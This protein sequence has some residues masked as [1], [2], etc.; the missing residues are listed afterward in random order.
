MS[1]P[2]LGID[3][4]TSNSVVSVLEA[5]RPT[6]I[7]NQ[8][9]ELTTASCVAFLPNGSVLVG[10]PARAGIGQR[11]ERTVR[12][13][14]RLV[15]R[16]S[17]SN[18]VT[19][20][21]QEMAFSLLANPQGDVRVQIDDRA[22]RLEEIAA[23]ILR[24]LASSAK[25]YLGSEDV[26]TAVITVPA[27]FNDNQRQAT[28]NAAM[29]AGLEPL[30]ILNEPTAA[31]LAYGYGDQEAKRVAVFDFGGGTFDL[32]ILEMGA[33]V[34]E[35]L[36]TGGDTYLGGD[37][38]DRMIVDDLAEKILKKTG[39][40]P[41][42]D[43]AARAVLWDLAEK[44]KRELSEHETVEIDLEVIA[45]IPM[46]YGLTRHRFNE[47]VTPL[48]ERSLEI[49]GEVLKEAETGTH[50]IDGVV[51]VGGTTRVPA[52]REA[53]RRYFRREPDTGID[54]DLVVSV[55]A[56]IYGASLSDQSRAQQ[57][58]L[59]VTPLTLRLGTVQKFT[60]AIIEKNA[61]IPTERT[62]TF[63]TSRDQQEYVAIRVFQGE[64]EFQSENTLLGEFA[65]GPLQQAPRGQVEIDVT[66]EIDPNGLVRV[67]ATDCQTGR[68]ASANVRLSVK[69]DEKSVSQ[70][71]SALP[72]ASS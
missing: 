18:E 32:S 49:C 59:D 2:V 51:L 34:L 35:V 10:N 62:R 65:F 12:S 16:S 54:P 46:V 4:G 53:V 69:M 63:V 55:G 9:G 58:L 38:M 25:S 36:A 24:D 42:E 41:R 19:K 26:K 47:L 44:S 50:L 37:D 8:D 22:Y 1:P 29:I 68:A 31:A 64:S 43:P 27:Y 57:I 23:M 28:R 3:L 48:I 17:A 14:K 30:R 6:V 20:A 61:P 52:V 45:G 39:R 7:A 40:D 15:G 67:T 70:A 72:K 56:A 71:T 60:E 21:Q 33:G 13:S 5:N 66:F 11:P